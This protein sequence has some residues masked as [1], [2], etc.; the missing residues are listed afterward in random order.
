MRHK[1]I[2][3]E[4]WMSSRISKEK[5][6]N[7]LYMKQNTPKLQPLEYSYLLWIKVFTI[8]IYAFPE[9]N[10]VKDGYS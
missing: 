9:L 5:L 7:I 10:P 1:K 4:A 3:K 8:L 2:W 6:S